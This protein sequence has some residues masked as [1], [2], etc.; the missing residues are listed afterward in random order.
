[1]NSLQFIARYPAAKPKAFIYAISGPNDALKAECLAIIRKRH[2]PHRTDV[3]TIQANTNDPTSALNILAQSPL[4]LQRTVEIGDFDT[5]KNKDLIYSWLITRN[6]PTIIPILLSTHKPRT[7]NQLA[8]L[9]IRKGWWVVCYDPQ[10]YQL[11]EYLAE[12]YHLS[13][14]SADELTTR[15]GNDLR[16]ARAI[17][18]KLAH[19]T[20]SPPTPDLI[21]EVATSYEGSAFTL[22]DQIIEG[23][24]AAALET[25]ESVETHGILTL[26]RMRIQSLMHIRHLRSMTKSLMPQQLAAATGTPMFRLGQYVS[27]SETIPIDKAAEMLTKIANADYDITVRGLRSGPTIKRLIVNL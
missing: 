12:R 26:L 22:I 10:P 21:R 17:L 27:Q 18:L 14:S 2:A 11:S 6:H 25:M 15:A 7:D 1:M 3:D 16:K 4:G 23:N 24:K 5:W 9:I 20:S 13:E 8:Q 19:L